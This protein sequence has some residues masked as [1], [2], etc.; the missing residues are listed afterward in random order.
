MSKNGNIKKDT[1]LG[2][3]HGTACNRLRKMVLFSLVQKLGEDV[4]FRCNKKIE[5]VNDL[6]IE[7][8]N[9]W[10]LAKNPEES[11]F[12]LKNITFSHLNCNILAS[13]R[14]GTRNMPLGKIGLRGVHKSNKNLK[15]PYIAQ[16]RINNQKNHLGYYE[17]P[18]QASKAYN[19]ALEKI[20]KE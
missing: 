20:D 14:T 15:K 7:H 9:S 4:C 10:Q 6:S 17:T 19:N 12:D 3:S 16:I 1:L 13:D 8:I 5:N 18:E 11:F 2:M